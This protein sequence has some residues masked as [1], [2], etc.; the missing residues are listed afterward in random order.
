MQKD[1]EDNPLKCTYI[2]SNFFQFKLS[3]LTHTTA[4][5]S[6]NADVDDG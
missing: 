6:H 2:K 5:T 3:E 1:V 4:L